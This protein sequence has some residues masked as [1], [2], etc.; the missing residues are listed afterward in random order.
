MMFVECTREHYDRLDDE[1]QAQIREKARAQLDHYDVR[2]KEEKKER[3]SNAQ[4]NLF[5]SSADAGSSMQHAASAQ[6]EEA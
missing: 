3:R 5:G 2:A 4:R 6:K 1:R